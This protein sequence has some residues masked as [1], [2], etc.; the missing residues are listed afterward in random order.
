MINI[1]GYRVDIISSWLNTSNLIQIENKTIVY[2]MYVFIMYVKL[3]T[4]MPAAMS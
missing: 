1:I 3:L 2:I 4:V